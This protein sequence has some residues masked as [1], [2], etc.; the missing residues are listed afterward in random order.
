MKA[1]LLL[2]LTFISLGTVAQ[3]SKAK[4]EFTRGNKIIFVDSLKG[5]LLGEFPSKWDLDFGSVELENL[6]GKW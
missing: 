5:E 6:M 2:V 3:T 1:I 4:S